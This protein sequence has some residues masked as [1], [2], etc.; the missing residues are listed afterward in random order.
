[1][2]KETSEI[3]EWAAAVIKDMRAG[4]EISEIA[5]G[6][7]QGLYTAVEGFEKLD[8]EAKHASRTHTLGYIT[9][10]IGEAIDD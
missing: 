1:V 2:G 3:G 7:L 9:A 8:D 5:A 10:K 4:K 6:N